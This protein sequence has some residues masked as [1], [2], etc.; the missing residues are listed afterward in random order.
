MGWPE[1]GFRARGPDGSASPGCA[2]ESFV[3]ASPREPLV[4]RTRLNEL[5]ECS[6]R[7][8]LAAIASLHVEDPGHRAEGSRERTARS[9]FEGLARIESRLL[10][11]HTG[12][13]H[14]LSMA[15]AVDDRPMAIQELDPCLSDIRNTNRV[16]KEPATRGRAAVLRGITSADPHANTGRLGFGECFEE[17]SVGHD[18]DSS[19]RRL[20]DGRTIRR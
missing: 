7:F 13:V 4:N 11:D 9:V 17:I 15:G 18:R 1:A 3:I 14:F 12:T 20:H 5:K 19:R 10:A 16:E 2:I 8:E 6:L